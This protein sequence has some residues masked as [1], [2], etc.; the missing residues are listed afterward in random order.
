MIQVGIE[1]GNVLHRFQNE[2]KP[3][4]ETS[5]HQSIYRL[6]PQAQACFHVH[7]VD[8]CLAASHVNRNALEMLLP[9]LEILKGLGIRE[10]GQEVGLPI[11]DNHLDVAQIARDI[12]YRFHQSPPPVS[13]LIIR[14]HGITVWGGSLQQTYNRVEIIEFIMGYMARQANAPSPG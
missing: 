13:A 1:N 12:D 8:A 10:E 6:Y 3:S 9:P 14:H 2:A 7:S 4:A 11:F 5:I